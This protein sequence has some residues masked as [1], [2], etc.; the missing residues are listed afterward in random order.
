M[1]EQDEFIQEEDEEEIYPQ[2]PNEDFTQ[3]EI[4]KSQNDEKKNLSTL[5]IN[6]ES[7]QEV[8][9]AF[10][11]ATA[12]LE[13][14]SRKIREEP[15]KQDFNEF[16]ENQKNDLKKE[17]ENSISKIK[18][19]EIK[20]PKKV[21]EEIINNLAYELSNF[22]DNLRV[23]KKSK[24]TMIVFSILVSSFIICGLSFAMGMMFQKNSFLNDYVVFFKANNQFSKLTD[25]RIIVIP[26]IQK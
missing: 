7:L 2:L 25:G 24:K 4:N 10:Q 22:S 19:P 21:D 26:S 18:F 6:L 1:V 23:I 16:F 13:E 5:A 12:K 3:E 14:A 11:F 20:E 15:R 9:L 17:I 8:L